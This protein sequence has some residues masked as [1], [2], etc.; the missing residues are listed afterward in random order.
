MRQGTAL[1]LVGGL[2]FLGV[3]IATLP[4]SL[5]VS[6][7]Q[8]ALHAEGVS[9]SVWNGAADSISLHGVP[10]GAFSWSTEP[11]A[12]LAGELALQVDITRPDGYVRGHVAATL[13]GA[14]V[15]DHVELA[16]PLAALSPTPSSAGWRGDFKGTIE[17][18][19]LEQG[20]PVALVGTFTTSTLRVPGSDLPIG[21]YA[22][23]FD[24]KANTPSQLVGR[25]RDVEA[26]L[27]VR[28]QMFIRHD[29]SYSLEGEVT[30][31]AGAGQDVTQAV[32][33][34][35]APDSSGRRAF[36]VTGTF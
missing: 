28:A 13:T 21:S 9:G 29:R 3:A 8:P 36:T 35:G 25:V 30:P 33:F 1:A 20:W 16:L 10:L 31:R 18:A 26:P 27:L 19:R 11:M 14:L 7:L 23:D 32:A 5:V 17:S 4:A 6:R 34:L 12:L 24:G 15:A 22:I 2:V